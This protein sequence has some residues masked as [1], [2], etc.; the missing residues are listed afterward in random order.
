M[1]ILLDNEFCVLST[2]RNDSPNSSLM[3][4]VLNES[5]TKLYMLTL[6]ESTKHINIINNPKVSLLIDTRESLYNEANQIKAV[7]VYGNASIIDHRK[8]MEEIIR[9]LVKK[10]TNLIAF[11]S[12]NKVCVIEV[13]MDHFLLLDGVDKS[14]HLDWHC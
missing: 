4:Y 1:K 6:K 12:N 3:Q 11:A 5:C 9:Q 14:F 10:H 2:C 7:T 13:C 8:T